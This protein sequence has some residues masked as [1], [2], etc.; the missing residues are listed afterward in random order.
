[1][2]ATYN[3]KLWSVVKDT[4][5]GV[6]LLPIDSDDEWDLIYVDYADPDLILD[7]TDDEVEEVG[8]L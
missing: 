6:N 3:G 7:P 4:W 2:K 5:E 8:C 1:M